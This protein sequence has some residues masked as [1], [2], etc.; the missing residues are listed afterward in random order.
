MADIFISYARADRPVIEALSAVLENAGHTV[1]WDRQIRGG[2]AYARD[3]E[4]ELKAARIVLVAWSDA[5][6]ASDWVKDE[7]AV[8]RDQGKLLPIRLDGGDQPLGFRQY[9]SIDLDGWR[10]EADAEPVRM[11]LT[12]I[13]ERLGAPAPQTTCAVSWVI[14]A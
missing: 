12:E 6:R 14:T 11:L 9:Q 7:A 5:S 10:G 2:S 1:W 4:S 8:A 13:A 3:I